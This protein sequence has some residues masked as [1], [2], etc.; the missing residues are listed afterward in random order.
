MTEVSVREFK[1]K[2]SEYL[3]RVE[4][5][6]E[7]AITRRGKVIGVMR[8]DENGGAGRAKTLEE[9]LQDLKR[10]GILTHVGG[11]FKPSGKPIPLRGEGPTLSEM[12]IADRGPR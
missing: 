5:G 8:A 2:L 4:A 6:E 1:N 11:K 12:I 3:R 10:R 9:K 7:I